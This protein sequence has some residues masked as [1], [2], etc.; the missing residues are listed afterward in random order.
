MIVY[1]LAMSPFV[2]KLLA[3]LAEK[4][5][6]SELKP[7]GL[8]SGGPEFKVAS[9]FGKV[10]ALVDGDYSL[11]DSTAIIAY[12]EAKHPEPALIPDEPKARGRAMWFDEFADTIVVATGAKMFF[13]RFVAPKMMKIAGDPAIADAAEAKE[14]PPILDYLESQIPASGFLVEDRMTIADVAVA[15]PFVNFEH[16]RLGIDAARY[17]RIIDYV[18]GIHARPS[19]AALIAAERRAVEAMG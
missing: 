10:P 9:P 5:L 13:N 2:R 4:G 15:S 8:G 14:L 6:E 19:F 12:L 3:Y 7:A 11:S 1:G 17:P 18:A 16:M